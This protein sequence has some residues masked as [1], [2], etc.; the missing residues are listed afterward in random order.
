MS[1]YNI[2]C[3]YF[4]VGKCTGYKNGECPYKYHKKC[5]NNF[6]C[7]DPN[8]KFGHGIS[9]MKREI[10]ND[11]YEECKIINNSVYKKDMCYYS[12]TCNSKDCDLEHELSYDNRAFIEKIANQSVTDDMAIDLYSKKY[13]KSQD[14]IEE[15]TEDVMSQASTA[16]NS[17][18]NFVGKSFKA[19][20]KEN[21]EDVEDDNNT[22]DETDIEKTLK[23]MLEKQQIV[24]NN[25]SKID[26]LREELENIQNEI[27]TY[28][29]DNAS[30]KEDIK[31]LSLQVSMM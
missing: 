25:N 19:V 3:P 8:C 6:T 27:I 22:L 15:K 1:Q 5:F 2:N 23:I 12:I 4:K 13:I 24:K 20:L 7:C 26:K 14:I 10:V 29:T 11:I 21:I 28:E 30:I 17:P 31:N 18:A 16:N 9:I